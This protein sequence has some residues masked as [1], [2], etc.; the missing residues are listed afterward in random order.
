MTDIKKHIK[1]ADAF[2]KDT[3]ELDEGFVDWVT[4]TVQKVLGIDDARADQIAGELRGDMSPAEIKAADEATSGAEQKALTKDQKDAI[5][6]TGKFK[7]T[8]QE[9]GV[10]QGID[11]ADQATGANAQ[12]GGEGGAPQNDGSV[13]AVG[14]EEDP[15]TATDQEGGVA[16]GMDQADQATDADPGLDA[17][18]GAGPEI[19]TSKGDAG[20]N[21]AGKLDLKTANLMK[22]YNDGGKQ[23]MPAVKDLQTALGRLGHDPNGIDGKYGQGTYNAVAAFQKANG[24]TVDGQAGPN[25]MK[26]IQEL[27]QGQKPKDA[28][29]TAKQDATNQAAADKAM[30]AGNANFA[31]DPQATDQ[32]TEQVPS[33]LRIRQV[34]APEIEK[35][36]KM[37]AES[38]QGMTHYRFIVENRAIAEKLDPPQL[39][40][41]QK[42]LDQIRASAK[43]DPKVQQEFGDLIKRMEKALNIP[44]QGVDGP[45]DD[46]AAQNQAAADDAQKQGDATYAN[47]PQATAK[48]PG[49]D[50]FGGKGPDIN[51]DT[52]DGDDLGNAPTAPKVSKEVHIQ[53]TGQ[54]TNFNVKDMKKKYPKP[55]VEIPQTDGTVIR[56]YGQ[57][58]A[59][60]IFIKNN[61][62]AKIIGAPKANTQQ[63][64]APDA[65]ADAKE[66]GVQVAEKE[67]NMKKQVKEASM[68]ISMNG[69]SSAEVAELIAILKNA[70][71][72]SNIP[73]MHAEPD[74][75][76]PPMGD[77]PCGMGEEAVDEE[78][79]NSPEET[80][81]DHHTM[82]KDLS[83][84]INREK[85]KGAIRAKDPAVHQTVESSIREQLWAAL[86]EK[87][88]ESKKNRGKKNRGMEEG[89]RGK[90]KNRGMEEGSRGKKKNRGMEEASRGKKKNRGMEEASRGKKKNRGMEEASRGKK[91][92]RGMEE[93]SRG[94]KKSRG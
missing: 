54:S 60:D 92:N 41:L 45:A 89:S 52:R 74:M 75:P 67:T 32:G 55:F 5:A 61:K 3:K 16:Q 94:K 29:A 21:L 44:Q 42:Y 19:D 68:N 71:M 78:W 85:P 35:L 47:D 23:A 28:D 87:F 82:T 62:G 24:L 90:K 58:Q 57:P 30:D 36:L 65:N 12:G 43:R 46:I 34:I 56:G 20:S 80:Y 59:L 27:L 1:I 31:D 50:A 7:P 39:A 53:S 2:G 86:N 64:G 4:S 83:G 10:A 66:R 91:K 84:G 77:S 11:Q 72:E 37:A 38:V 26:K 51:T 15:G 48:E 69:S 81:A 18:G 13:D 9:G 79:D 8:D 49:L 6:G 40:Q 93:A 73:H 14:S 70:G 17:F 22:A 88:D 63:S 25:T 76:E 33:R